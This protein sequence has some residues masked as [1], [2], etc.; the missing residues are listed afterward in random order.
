MK[1]EKRL[2]IPNSYSSKKVSINLLCDNYQT[3]VILYI[4]Q[5]T[6]SNLINIRYYVTMYI[7]IKAYHE[8]LLCNF[9]NSYEKEI[10]LSYPYKP[11][12]E[13]GLEYLKQNE[14]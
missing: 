8:K 3:H 4:L 6:H 11:I 5:K 10:E 2:E 1:Q 14:V 9:H 13:Q 7:T 12:P